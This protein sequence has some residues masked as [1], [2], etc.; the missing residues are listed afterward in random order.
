MMAQLCTAS[1]KSNN[2]PKIM[3]VYASYLWSFVLLQGNYGHTFPIGC[4]DFLQLFYRLC[5][6]TSV[7]LLDVELLPRKI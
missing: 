4:V 7:Q 5:I 3:S 6:F 1:S 2:L